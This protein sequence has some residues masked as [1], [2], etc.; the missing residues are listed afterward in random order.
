MRARLAVA[1]GLL[2]A[3]FGVFL[4]GPA[5]AAS[6]VTLDSGFVTDRSGVLS[7]S[8]AAALDD[9][10]QT[11]SRE[12]HVELFVVFVDSFTDPADR[13]QWA[14]EVAR[15]NGLG[16][17]QY[18]LAI[19]TQSRQYYIS[20]DS[21]GPVS[22]TR[23]DQIEQSMLPDL[24]QDRWADAVSTAADGFGGA[25]S[26]GGGDGGVVT[27]VI[28]LIVV[29]A[30]GIIIWLLVRARR[31]RVTGGGGTA[32][33]QVGPA[34]PYAGIT[35]DELGK[36]AGS[37]LV[38][39][40]DAIT[41][42]TEDLGFATA[43]FGDAATSSFTQV[44]AEAKARLDEA[45]SL[46]QQL[47]D[48]IP[49]T[50]EQRRAWHIRIIE[51]CAAAD[52][53][54]DANVEAFDALRKLEQNAEQAL[55]QATAHRAQ[56]EAAVTAAPAALERLAAGY[57][58]TALRTVADNPQQARSRLQ[59]A[60]TALADASAKLAAGQRGE[61]AFAIR[62]AEE[63]IVQAQQLSEAIGSLGEALA[64]AE[65]QARALIADLESDL[66]GAAAL[67]STP[68]LQQIAAATRAELDAA[69][70]DLSGT[71]RRPQ[72]TLEA[73]SA[74]NTRIDSAVE[75]IR[76][77]QQQA[78]RAAQILDQTILQ[79]RA[80]VSSA[81]DFITTRRGA[82][83]ATA[84]T[85]VAEA[86]AELS[87]AEA[88][89]DADP[90]QAQRSAER[91]VAL[92]REAITA[93]QNDVNGFGSGGGFGGGGFGGGGG[94]GGGF[95]GDIL[96]GIIGGI[97]AGGGSGGRGGGYRGGGSSGGWRSSGGGRGFSPSSF[98][99]SRGRS[100]GGRF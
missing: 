35:D 36:R 57:D 15:S 22:D 42:S 13:Q 55:Q 1:T 98:G 80:E 8:D 25:G 66:A 79:A 99:G 89:R 4:A 88:A 19:A 77:A 43:Q 91:A 100:G 46:K 30:A 58:P 69:G 97:L 51:L 6:P 50:P 24:Q 87:R 67:P 65:D 78:A 3:L 64:A 75:R 86:S 23:L 17:S 53:A 52:T 12:Q 61:A 48:E 38:Q 40:D 28:V 18:L 32:G 34:D 62:T 20:A 56:V 29:I 70:A 73:L 47:D 92:A 11:L 84:R 7:T 96:G 63:G 26:S 31:R 72:A 93:A 85:R 16:S 82:V 41:S 21:A 45:F 44:V 37:A 94:G 74:A 49:D 68:E 9:R 76:D 60:D 95:A 59:L 2:L 39:T 27:V 33:G 71:A 14:D 83:G 81:N 54:L 90:V 5:S 10:L